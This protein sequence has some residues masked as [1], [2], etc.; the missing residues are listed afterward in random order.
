MTQDIMP[1]NFFCTWP[2]KPQTGPKA[3][4]GC[5]ERTYGTKKAQNTKKFEI[6]AVFLK[7]SLVLCQTTEPRAYTRVVFGG[8]LARL[9]RPG[10][11][12]LDVPWSIR[13]PRIQI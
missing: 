12:Y 6:Q 5:S 2:A 1:N 3:S 7:K 8:S 10:W 11:P 4:L 9:A 13:P